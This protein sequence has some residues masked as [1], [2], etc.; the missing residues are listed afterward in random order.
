MFDAALLRSELAPAFR[1][2]T[3][4][5]FGSVPRTVGVVPCA[6][7]YVATDSAGS[8]NTGSADPFSYLEQAITLN[9]SLRAVGLPQLTVATNVAD[10]AEQY[11]AKFDADARP[12]IV[13]LAPSTLTLPKVTRFYG[14]HFKLDMMEQLG[15]TLQEGELLM[16]LDTDMLALHGVDQELL[17]RCLANGV[18]AFDI[19]DQEFSAYGDARVIADLETVAGARLQ[20]PRWF[21]GEIL[22]ASAG[23]IA[24]LVPLAH[25]CFERYSRAINELNHNGD[26]AFVSAALNL[27]A[28][29]GHQIIDLGAHR[30]IGRHWSGN[31][32]RDLRW[33]KGCTLLHLPGSKQL[34]E[35]EARRASFSAAHVWRRLVLAHELHRPVWPLR[36]WLRAWGWPRFRVAPRKEQT[37]ARVDVLVLDPDHTR[38]SKLASKLTTLG[39]QVMS[40]ITSHEAR[41]EAQRLNPRVIV[42]SSPLGVIDASELL[43]DMHGRRNFVQRP[44]MIAFSVDDARL[45]WAEWDRWFPRSADPSDIAQAVTEALGPR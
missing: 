7:V 8:P 9:R 32:H 36:R 23:F 14:S 6:L 40:T 39:M 2:T 21:G 3:R 30:F 15:A 29:R 17:R 10:E 28:D 44:V 31:T 18:G 25:A 11:L 38:L 26:E 4:P 43:D 19:S 37:A 41:A 13:Q 33:Y 5:S 22:L 35:H 16:V 12:R 20:N 27:L 34:L 24:E 1:Q 42:A 45:D